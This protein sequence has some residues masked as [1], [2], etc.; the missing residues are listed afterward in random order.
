MCDFLNCFCCVLARLAAFSTTYFGIAGHGE[1][2]VS[3]DVVRRLYGGVVC[4]FVCS[5]RYVSVQ[6]QVSR[7][8]KRTFSVVSICSSKVSSIHVIR[9]I[10]QTPCL[11]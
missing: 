10:C 2:F 7:I 9:P 8:Q 11:K 3:C 1:L 6:H 5:G 4:E